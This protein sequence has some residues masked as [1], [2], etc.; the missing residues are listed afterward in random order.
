MSERNITQVILAKAVGVT[1]GAVSGW[2][3]GGIPKIDK[4]I[5]IAEVLRVSP[6]DLMFPGRSRSPVVDGIAIAKKVGGPRELQTA[7]VNASASVLSERLLREDVTPFVTGARAMLKSAREAKGM[8][9]AEMAKVIGYTDISTYQNI[10]EGRSQMG[11]KMARKAAE[12]LGIDVSELMD[13]SDHPI[14]RTPSVGTFGAVPD[15]RVPPGMKAKFVPLISLAECGPDMVW[16]DDGYNGEG[17]LALDCTDP[18]AFA[19]QL[20]GDSMQPRYHAGDKA[21]ITPSAQPYNGDVVL[22]KLKDEHGGDVMIKLYQSSNG[23]VTLSSYN[24]VYKDIVWPR[25]AFAFIYPVDQI[26][27]SLR[28]RNR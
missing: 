13:G 22:A 28:N 16:T 18:K 25:T 11:E 12:I 19:V 24:P 3:N 15:I 4:V 5:K 10:E 9:Q 23:T 1:Q 20:S 17:V 26:L 8:T 6:E 14:D 27:H 2:L 7:I 21:I